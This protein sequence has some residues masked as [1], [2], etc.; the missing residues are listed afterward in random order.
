[1]DGASEALF[2]T[3]LREA[4]TNVLRHAAGAR[5]CE[6]D[7]GPGL[8]RVADDGRAVPPPP[9]GEGDHAGTGGNGLRNLRERAAALG[10]ILEAGPAPDGRGYVLTV[11]LESAPVSILV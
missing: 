6:V 10:G 7:L 1:M 4:V 5:R 3:V 11:R 9:R 2:A 8:L